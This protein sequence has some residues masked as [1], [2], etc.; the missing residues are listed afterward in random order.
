MDRRIVVHIGYPKTGTMSIQAFL[1]GARRELRKQGILY[2]APRFPPKAA[3]HNLAWSLLD[4]PPARFRRDSLTFD[5]IASQFARADA[6]VMVL[7]SEDFV[8]KVDQS[9]LARAVEELAEET[10]ASVDVIAFIRAQHAYV[11]SLYGQRVKFLNEPR[12]F[13]E[14]VKERVDD[15]LLDYGSHLSPWG[16]SPNLRFIPIP[17]TKTRLTPDLETSF[18]E[19][20]GIADR[21]AGALEAADRKRRNPSPG[22]LTV[23]ASRRVAAHLRGRAGAN[24]ID[25]ATWVRIV[26][27]VQL[28]LGRRS[29]WN[30]RPFNGVDNELQEQIEGRFEASNRAFA[31]RYWN[32]DWREVFKESYGGDLTP[33]EFGRAEISAADERALDRVVAVTIKRVDRLLDA[34]PARSASG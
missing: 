26:R 5:A 9:K 32:A 12:R 14:F 20:A 23:E 15:E 2:P 28:T 3:Q 10:G 27:H 24:G 18:C 34:L 13:A 4:D 6:D 17:F 19:A 31:R 22:P 30:S 7:S 16:S 1:S 21:A 8:Q 25:Y 33:N 29:D 11:N